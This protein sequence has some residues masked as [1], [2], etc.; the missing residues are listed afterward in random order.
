M[1]NCL[2]LAFI[3]LM[4]PSVSDSEE[5]R[6]NIGFRPG[7]ARPQMPMGPPYTRTRVHS[8]NGRQMTQKRID[9]CAEDTVISFIY[10][11]EDEPHSCEITPWIAEE[12]HQFIEDHFLNCTTEAMR[13]AGIRE[14]PERIQVA[15]MGAHVHRP[16]SMHSSGAS[17]D[18]GHL[19]V[20]TRSGRE[21]TLPTAAV[22]RREMHFLAFQGVDLIATAADGTELRQRQGLNSFLSLASELKSRRSKQVGATVLVE[23]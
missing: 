18:V 22:E 9:S 16:P 2:K 12:A 5:V 23:F 1:R 17:I 19:V 21:L 20:T 8:I 3:L 6:R 10:H 15:H 11:V 13:E 4:L 7:L 14:T